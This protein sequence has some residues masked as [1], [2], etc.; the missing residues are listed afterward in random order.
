MGE[1]IVYVRDK[2]NCGITTKE[3]YILNYTQFFTPNGDG[4]NDAWRIQF[5]ENELPINVKIYDRYGKILKQIKPSNSGWDGTY[6]GA[7]LKIDLST[8]QV[9]NDFPNMSTYSRSSF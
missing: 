5:S 7:N 2:H 8:N 1:L 6:N 4:Y 3:I 9:G